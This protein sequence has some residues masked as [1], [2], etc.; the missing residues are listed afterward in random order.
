M[1][2]EKPSI[3]FKLIYDTLQNKEN[4]LSVAYLCRA[5]GVSKS[6]YYNWLKNKPKR[7]DREIKDRKDFDLILE[8]YNYK[9]Y[10]KGAR[11]IQMRLKRDKNIN[12]NIKK[13]RRLMK[14]I[15]LV[16]PN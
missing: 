1:L 7:D 16:L 5:S 8:A 2:N 14:K 10:K 11:S 15:W 12:W 6:G 9:G 13:I 4:V 3:I